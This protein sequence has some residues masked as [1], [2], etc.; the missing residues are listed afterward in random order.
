M[1]KFVLRVWEFV[2]KD[3]ETAVRLVRDAC[4][5]QLWSW[6]SS[7][8]DLTSRGLK[9]QE[10]TFF[11][12]GVCVG[13][14]RRTCGS[15]VSWSAP[16]TTLCFSAWRGTQKW[17]TPSGTRFMLV[18]TEYLWSLFLEGTVLRLPKDLG[19]GSPSE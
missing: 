13:C 12:L 3:K 10:T 9:T 1:L 8:I 15:G 5:V 18:S 11:S 7:L 19:S 14:G 16:P 6:F 17:C 2:G 4:P